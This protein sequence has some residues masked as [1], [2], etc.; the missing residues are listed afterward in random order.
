MG[1]PINDRSMRV[2][3]PTMTGQIEIFLRLLSNSSETSESVN[4]TDRCLRLGFDVIGHLAFGCDLKTQTEETNR[5]MIR[6][7]TK[8]KIRVNAFMHFPALQSLD[9][10]LKALPN[11]DTVEFRRIVAEII[12]TRIAEDDRGQHDLYALMAEHTKPGGLFDGI[13]WSEAIFFITAGGGTTAT[14]MSALFFYLSRYPECYSRLAHEIRS[15]FAAGREIQ[16]GATLSGCKYLRAC[17]DESLRMAPPSL[18][19]LWREQAADDPQRGT[20]PVVVDGHAIPPGTQ[21]GVNLYALHHNAE[22]F[23]DPFTFDP[24]RF[25]GGGGGGD[26]DKTG[27]HRAFMPFIV[28]ARS[29][30]GKAMAYLEISLVVAKT[31]WYFDFEKAAG[32][33]GEI[34]QGGNGRAD[35]FDLV[36][37]FNAH[38]DGPYL[39]FKRRV[40]CP[41][42]L[43]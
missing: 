14:T 25:M 39:V 9:F 11:K 16:G 27:R 40:G 38:H 1:Q 28:G 41:D 29:C 37:M 30:A 4:M 36:D 13:L 19:T 43:D 5:V 23:P 2:F 34:G 22:Y 31:M 42:E 12:K 35:V 20:G 32:P 6:L 10:I 15:T 33:L 7:L 18:A 24:E 8:A 26:A 3:E 21:V 17:I